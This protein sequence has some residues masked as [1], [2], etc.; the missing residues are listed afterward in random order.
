M[1]IADNFGLFVIEDAA[2][3]KRVVVL[4]IYL[5]SRFSPTKLLLLEKEGCVLQMS[6]N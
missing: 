5:A 6:T 2:E 4:A 1:K 3:A